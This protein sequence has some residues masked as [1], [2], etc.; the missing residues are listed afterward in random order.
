MTAPVTS[1][2]LAARRVP[3]RLRPARDR[4]WAVHEGTPVLALDAFSRGELCSAAMAVSRESGIG[5]DDLAY[6]AAMFIAL[7]Q[8]PDLSASELERVALDGPC[9]L[10]GVAEA[11]WS[12]PAVTDTLR[13]EAAWSVRLILGPERGYE[14]LADVGDRCG[15]AVIMG[16]SGS[17]SYSQFYDATQRLFDAG[18]GA[19]E[20][21]A[22]FARAEPDQP[23]PFGRMQDLIGLSCDVT[24]SGEDQ[25]R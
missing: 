21:L 22:A 2:T 5:T 6:A 18:R 1:S 24:S 23:V 19:G 10:D 4:L 17:W 20:V 9:H 7:L 8:H 13:R 12:H 3:E 16:S 14:R 15:V 11:F 25:I